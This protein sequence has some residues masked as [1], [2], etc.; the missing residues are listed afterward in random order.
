[1]LKR[2]SAGEACLGLDGEVSLEGLT[3]LTDEADRLTNVED[4]DDEDEHNVETD[5]MDMEEPVVAGKVEMKTL[6]EASRTSVA[7]DFMMLGVDLSPTLF[8]DG[9]MVGQVE[10]ES[11]SS[12]A[13]EVGRLEPSL[14]LAY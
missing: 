2:S 13:G 6:G 7:A 8:S 11:E 5:D 4:E 10:G 12:P 14:M 1:M 3:E 9:V